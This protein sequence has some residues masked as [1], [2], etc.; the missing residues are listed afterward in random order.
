MDFITKISR[1]TKQH[2]SIMVVVDKLTK[3]S[4]F[5]PMK[6]THKEANISYIYMREIARLHGVPKTIVS[7]RHPKF[8]S[9]FWNGLF[10]GFGTNM[11]FS[12][13]YHPES[14][15]KTK[16]VNQ[17]IE[18]MLRMYVMDKPSKWKDY[19]HLVEFSY[20]NGYQESLN[21]SPFEALYGRKCNTPVS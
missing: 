11:N 2:N 13:A 3:A 15:G 21:M 1:T 16:R 7:D 12:I 9:N 20:N 4:H 10:K 18:D 5:I 14:N 8:K 17:V 19:L 6:L